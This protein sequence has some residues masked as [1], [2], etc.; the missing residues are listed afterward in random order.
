MDIAGREKKNLALGLGD[1]VVDLV[2]HRLGK[3]TYT[4]E[5]LLK[6][7]KHLVVKSR[8]KLVHRLKLGAMVQEGESQ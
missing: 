6:E 3:A 7:A 2:F 5:G 8:N 4:E 1:E